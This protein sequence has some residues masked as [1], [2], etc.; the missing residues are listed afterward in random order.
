MSNS[1]SSDLKS[2][3]RR[4]DLLLAVVLW[5]P[6]VVLYFWAID[7]IPLQ[8]G[9]YRTLYAIRQSIP[10][11]VQDRL[12]H[13]HQPFFYFFAWLGVRA[14]GSESVFVLRLLPQL[15]S[16]AA[17]G[18]MYAAVRVIAG[19]YAAM[20][21]V[22]LLMLTGSFMWICHNIR[23]A[24]F[25]ALFSMACLYLI[26]S[27]GDKPSLRRLILVGL[28]AF[29]ALF[30]Y[31]AAIPAVGIM[32]LGV[33]FTGPGR[34]RL[35]TAMITA[36]ITYTPWFLYSKSKYPVS[37]RLGWL[38]PGEFIEWPAGILDFSYNMNLLGLA[39]EQT[40]WALPAASLVWLVNLIV[41]VFGISR[42]RRFG[43][44]LG[45]MWFFPLLCGLFSLVFLNANTMQVE[46]YYTITV[47]CQAIALAV[48]LTAIPVRPR[49]AWARP[50]A[51]AVVILA[52]AFG[53]AKELKEPAP[54][55]EM[56]LVYYI[57]DHAPDVDMV[58]VLQHSRIKF[59]IENYLDVNVHML[60]GAY[61]LESNRDIEKF[62]V[63]SA[64]IGQPMSPLPHEGADEL[65][66]IE[67][68]DELDI[69]TARTRR[70]ATPAM[71]DAVHELLKQYDYEIV[72]LDSGRIYHLRARQNTPDPQ[73][74]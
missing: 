54:L 70:P 21:A 4:W 68:R 43:V 31:N 55:Y 35:F 36:V 34:W 2:S 3:T 14:F 72:T 20:L 40:W 74:P 63:E 8:D 5:L 38:K 16:F 71:R 24:S 66:I 13:G 61:G 46:R 45:L 57:R 62:G 30:S 12:K 26:V 59:Q 44:L 39:H 17:L 29:C 27:A 41:I 11:L 9:E 47:F 65:L 15:A 60:A 28:T 51:C 33:L 6:L 42:I 69:E 37:D 49:W 23:P 1:V 48:A 73:A 67:Y 56:D 32:A 25:L 10:V 18:F 64:V 22:T 52:A 7:R 58:Y 19:R 53:L 50:L